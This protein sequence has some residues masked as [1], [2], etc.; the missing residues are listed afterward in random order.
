MSNTHDEEA[1]DGEELLNVYQIPP[2]LIETSA[3]QKNL[4]KPDYLKESS[5]KIPRELVYLPGDPERNS[6]QTNL[7]MGAFRNAIQ[8]DVVK[9]KS[10]KPTNGAEIFMDS[11]HYD[12]PDDLVFSTL[13]VGNSP[14]QKGAHYHDG[15]VYQIPKNLVKTNINDSI[16][17]APVPARREL[18]ADYELPSRKKGS[19]ITKVALNFQKNQ[20]SELFRIKS[21]QSIDF[22]SEKQSSQV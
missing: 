5:Y 4:F 10:K 8:K 3:A 7:F 11:D 2:G 21:I 9:H 15:D 14:I 1:K 19:S 18:D 13:R 16:L 22:E 6:S 20:R 12:I 17:S